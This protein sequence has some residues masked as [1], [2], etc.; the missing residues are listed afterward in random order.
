MC[1]SEPQIP[2]A[3][4]RTIASVRDSS[5]GD[6][7]SSTRTSPGAWNVTALIVFMMSRLP[8]GRPAGSLVVG[9]E[10][11]ARVPA[12]LPGPDPLQQ[13]W[14]GAIAL[15][16]T[17]VDE[18]E[19]HG[20]DVVEPDLVRP[21]ENPARVVEAVHH[22]GVNVVSVSNPLA[23]GERGLVYDLAD[24]PPEHEAWRV[25][26]PFGALAQRSEEALGGRHR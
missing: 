12:E 8:T 22:A 3:S 26:D 7:R 24:D 9:E 5:S 17:L 13:G 25:G 6:G 23:E 16:S 4:I 1:R 14:G 15:L 18:R 20:E 21:A 11:G 19:Q 2:L 10:A